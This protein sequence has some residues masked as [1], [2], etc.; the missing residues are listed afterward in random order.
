MA[1]IV[2]AAAGGPPAAAVPAGIVAGGFPLGTELAIR[3]NCVPVE[4]HLRLVIGHVSHER[5]IVIDPDHEVYEEECVADGIDTLGVW[6]LPPG[7]GLPFGHPGGAYFHD[8]A[9][10]P[11]GVAPTAAEVITLCIQGQA[12]AHRQRVAQGLLLPAGA[13]GALPV[14]AAVPPAGPLV[15]PVGALPAGVPPGV[16]GALVPVGGALAGGGLGALAAALAGGGG[17]GVPP[18]GG[19]PGGPLGG[20]ALGGLGFGGAPAGAVPPPAVAQLAPDLRVMPCRYNE[21]DV[22]FRDP[23]DGMTLL[24]TTPFDDFPLKGPRSCSWVIC[25]MVTQAGSC[26]AWHMQ[27][28]N[29][30]KLTPSDPGVESHGVGCEVLHHAHC[31]DQL[32]SGNLACL[33]AVAREVQTQELRYQDRVV[34]DASSERAILAG[35]TTLG[36]LCIMP[37]L[38]VYL[39]EE[40]K[41]KNDTEKERRKAREER[42]LARPPNPK[43]GGQQP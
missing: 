38:R 8:W 4:D 25:H 26:R 28:R 32:N 34:V 6:V 24:S 1:A 12:E 27:F 10:G 42:G 23:R 31:Y 7:G 37:E 20:A 35:S 22:R 40:L 15:P 13:P 39:R 16:A 29:M 36:N 3:Y 21:A 30:C 17:G 41:V 11:G 5:Y 33:E 2:A 18:P 43:K 19:P 14:G 9:S